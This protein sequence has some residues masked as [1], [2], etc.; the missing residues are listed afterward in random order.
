[1]QYKIN[2]E[3][4]KIFWSQVNEIGLNKETGGINRIGFSAA[5]TEARNWLITQL[6]S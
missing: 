4:L 3:R 5:D 2:S 1:M 6:K